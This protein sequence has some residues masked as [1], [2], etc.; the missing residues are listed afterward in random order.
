MGD[1][2]LT[3]EAVTLGHTREQSTRCVRQCDGNLV[4]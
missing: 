3:N 4:V 1:F 2:T